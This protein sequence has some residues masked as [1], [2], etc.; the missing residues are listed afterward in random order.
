[1]NHI[2]KGLHDVEGVRGSFIFDSQGRVIHHLAHSLYDLPLLEMIS[3]CMLK[4]S[5][6]LQLQLEDWEAV[7]SHYTEGKLFI[8]RVGGYYLGVIADMSLN[9]SFAGL[10]LRVATGKLKQAIDA[11]T[12]DQ[13]SSGANGSGAIASTSGSG[14]GV[15]G[16]GISRP[17]SVGSGSGVGWS[18]SGASG[19]SGVSGVAAADGS[20]ASCLDR[21]SKALAH[22][23]GPMAKVLVKEA[24]G[25]V[26]GGGAFSTAQFGQLVAELELRI[27]KPEGRVLFREKLGL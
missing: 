26:S 1:M 27:P 3:D 8:R 23:L 20:A 22:V 13:P 24:A 11:G 7:N 16:P 14:P 21:C 2:L 6:T 10:A 25:R 12:I 17:A 18:D 9:V 19:T 15:S 5:E 4:A